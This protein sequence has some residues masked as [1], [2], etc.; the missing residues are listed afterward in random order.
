M[1]NR[2]NL[3][4]LILCF[5]LGIML[6]SQFK[7]IDS[8]VGIISIQRAQELTNELKNIKEERKA[9]YEE[10][11]LL[12]Q[13]MREYEEAAAQTDELAEA[14][15]KELERMRILA[16]ITD[17]EG[18][19]II[20]LLD[21]SKIPHQVGE[22]PNLFLIHDDDILKVV[23]ELFAAGAE[24][25]SINEQR[26]I[27]TSEIRCVGPT[28]SINNI[29]FSPPYVIKAIGNPKTLEASL[30]LRGGVIETL[31]AWGIEATIKIQEN[32]LVPG[33]KGPIKFEYA[34]PAKVGGK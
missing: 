13:K 27:S 18:P 24:A 29:K 2:G 20:V 12:R 3:I 10:L 11:N 6:V 25:V 4:I 7:S 14:L 34:Q 30:K 15:K 19:G 21:D 8:G 5:L 1:N 17:V 33:Y 9:L 16:G 32:V 28:I 31:H 23:N 26:L 22:N